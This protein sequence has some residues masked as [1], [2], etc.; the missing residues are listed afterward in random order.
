MSLSTRQRL[1]RIARLREHA[2]RRRRLALAQPDAEGVH[3]CIAD[4][5]ERDAQQ[6]ADTLA[7]QQRVAD[8]R[9]GTA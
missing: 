5:F 7:A 3:T 2:Q 8:L 9:R 6:E 1:A 4:A